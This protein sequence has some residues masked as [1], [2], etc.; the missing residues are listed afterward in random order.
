MI[1]TSTKFQKTFPSA[2]INIKKY[3]KTYKR[4]KIF[5]RHSEK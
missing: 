2:L 3:F 1:K 5:S 4:R